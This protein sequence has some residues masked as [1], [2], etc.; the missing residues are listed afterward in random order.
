MAV[1]G[2]RKRGKL[3]TLAGRV[4]FT[5]TDKRLFPTKARLG[6]NLNVLPT[7]NNT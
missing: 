6:A 3:A 5:R 2:M 7:V 1:T 4:A